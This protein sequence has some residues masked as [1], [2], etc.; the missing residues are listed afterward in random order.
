MCQRPECRAAIP[1]D[2]P[3]ADKDLA[4]LALDGLT[5]Y[6]ADRA[7]VEVFAGAVRAITRLG[8][9]V[10]AFKDLAMETAQHRREAE[11]R[12]GAPE[13]RAA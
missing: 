5:A 11:T 7:G 13:G 3:Q 2:W 6:F 12:R 1:S 4:A 8:L 10:T 9:D